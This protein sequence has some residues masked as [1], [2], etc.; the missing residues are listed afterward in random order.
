MKRNDFVQLRLHDPKM[1]FR[2]AFNYLKLLATEFP[3]VGD[4]KRQQKRLS[5]FVKNW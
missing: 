4:V 3:E 2:E 5:F 1:S